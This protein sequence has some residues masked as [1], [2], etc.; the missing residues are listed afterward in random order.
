M[1]IHEPGQENV[2]RSL[3]GDVRGVTLQ[4][5]GSRYE[6]QN[7]PPVDSQT[8]VFAHGDL[9]FD[10]DRPARTNQS[11]DALT[12]QEKIRV[13]QVAGKPKYSRSERLETLL[14]NPALW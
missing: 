4:G 14:E 9:G 10:R 2:V 7:P 11:V 1:G 8:E 5:L 6:R 3:M 12:H 13:R